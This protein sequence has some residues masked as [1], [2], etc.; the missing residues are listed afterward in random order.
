MKLSCRILLFLSTLLFLGVGIASADS[1]PLVSYTLT[2]GPVTASFTLPEMPTPTA[3]TLGADF[4]VNPL[5]L[6]INGSPSNDVV[7]FYST[8]FGGALGAFSSG[9]TFDFSLAGPQLYSGTEANPLMSTLANPIPL[10]DFKSGAFFG[11]LTATIVSTPEPSALALLSAGIFALGLVAVGF[12]R[13]FPI[14]AAE[15]K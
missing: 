3:W 1:V 11:N 14:A 8:S 9:S 6:M 4:K 15:Q 7:L 5:N 12:K 13:R 10:F 2:G